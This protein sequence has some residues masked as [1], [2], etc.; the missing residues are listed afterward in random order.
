MT[1]TG[2][3][4]RIIVLGGNQVIGPVG[5]IAPIDSVP[6][7]VPDDTDE[8]RLVTPQAWPVTRELA[9]LADRPWVM[10]PVGTPSREWTTARCRDAGFEPL[11]QPRRKPKHFE[12]LTRRNHRL[13]EL[14]IE[15]NGN[16]RKIKP[17]EGGDPKWSEALQPPV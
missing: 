2:W 3:H 6:V 5:G 12:V 15:L 16:I 13:T 10:E 1:K 7:A 17:V 8:L 9:R 4:G 11:G 14:H